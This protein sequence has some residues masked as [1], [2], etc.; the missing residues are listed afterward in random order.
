MLILFWP[1][2]GN[3]FSINLLDNKL[4]L[5]Y[6]V[7]M[8]TKTQRIHLEIQTHRKNCYGLL[9][10]S[11]WEDNVVKHQN[12]G[13]LTGL[14]RERLKLIQAALRGDAVHVDSKKAPVIKNSKEY[15][16]S[17]VVLQI[18]KQLELDSA[19]YS[20]PNQP[21]VQNCLAM[22]AGRVVYAGSKLS[23]TNR[24][25]DTALWEL[26]GIDGA[27]DVDEHCYASMDKLFER[28]EA[29][30]KKLAA[31]HFSGNTLVLY[32][33]TS[34]YFEGE[35]ADSQLVK[36]GYNRDKKR[37]TEQVVIGLICTP[38]GCPIAV[39]VFPG[40]TKDET[41]VVGRIEILQKTFGIKELI[42]VGDRGMVT[43]SNL[44]KIKTTNG[45]KTI[46]ALTHPQI[47]SLLSKKIIQTDM[48]DEKDIMEIIDPDDLTRRYCLCYNPD[49]DRRESATRKA[50]LDKT[51]KELNKIA[52]STRKS[53]GDKIAAR[54]GKILAQTKMGKF[55]DWEVKE[56]R[57]TWSL[58]QDAV[59]AEI[60]LDGCYII[61]S[62]VPKEQMTKVE[63]VASYKK[64][65]LVELAFRNLKTVQLEMRPVYHKTDDRIC[66]H[67]FLCM[68]AYYLQWNMVQRLK[69][70]FAKDG[71]HQKRFWTFENVIERLK[72]IRRE[73]MH[74]EGTLCKITTTPDDEQKEILKLLQVGL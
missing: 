32:D 36:F 19:I 8:K 64:L 47:M 17:Y 29:I 66:C 1:Y 62:D 65:G 26:C 57:L 33:I 10:S 51:T 44:E 43:Q 72:S 35:Y 38:E 25:K 23:L 55:I 70:L 40:N 5:I 39:E 20:K 61:T 41:T 67:V 12:H 14:S 54:V 21:W 37:G 50:L 56:S 30:Q 16:A 59:N 60:A 71:K 15:G 13:R 9:R 49:S 34:S 18:A 69:P 45:L 11:Y 4:L 53:S 7:A 63:L 58:D 28:Q 6:H 73:E 31:K 74:V 22:I 42:F 3:K 68:L 27:V 46:S 2:I 52:A 48:F 24:Y